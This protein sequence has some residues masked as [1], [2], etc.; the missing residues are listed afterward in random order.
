MRSKRTLLIVLAMSSALLVGGM[1]LAGAREAEPG[2]DHGAVE[3]VILAYA[4]I[5]FQRHESQNG[6]RL[7]PE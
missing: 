3:V 1:T 2:D 6:F 5:H 7:A 4:R